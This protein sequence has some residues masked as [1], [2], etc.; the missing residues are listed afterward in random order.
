M[1]NNQNNTSINNFS[2]EDQIDIKPMLKTLYR[3]KKYLFGI[4]LITSIIVAIFSL[5]EVPVWR[6]NFQ[7]VIVFVDMS[8][9]GLVKILILLLRILSLF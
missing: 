9:V 6:G 7:I 5:F 2:S 8:F 1:K 4:P 3:G